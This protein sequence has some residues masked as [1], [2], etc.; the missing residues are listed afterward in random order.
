MIYSSTMHNKTGSKRPLEIL[1]VYELNEVSHREHF[2]GLLRYLSRKPLWHLHVREPKNGLT[3]KDITGENGIRYDGFIITLPG[4]D[5]T[6][7]ALARSEIPTVLVNIDHSKLTRRRKNISTVWLDNIGIGVCGARHFLERE[8]FKSYGFIACGD[9]QF[10]NRERESGFRRTLADSGIRSLSLTPSPR[11]GD[12][13]GTIARWIDALPKPCAIMCAEAN[14]AVLAR[15]ACKRINAQIPDQVALLSTGDNVDL[16]LHS[17]PPVSCVIPEFGDMG[18]A[19]AKELDQIIRSKGVRRFHEIIIQTN[20][21]IPRGSTRLN[22]S[23][24]KI[25]DECLEFINS[26]AESD[27]SVRDVVAL[28]HLSRRTLENYFR[29]KNGKGIRETIEKV[30]LEKAKKLI[31]RGASVSQTAAI[32]HFGSANYLS[33]RYKHHYGVSASEHRKGIA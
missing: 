32:L 10:Y 17:S 33:Q 16:S 7:S 27:V 19:A 9:G 2:S 13:T 25:V 30:K 28:F 21:V 12:P 20:K 14:T 5:E 18:F 22:S 26:M 6:M 3:A 8:A 23:A 15:N 11:D 4:S 31:K 24:A 29:E 1:A